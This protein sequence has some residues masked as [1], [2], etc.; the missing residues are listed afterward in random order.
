MGSHRGAEGA[1]R[2]SARAGPW[3]AQCGAE[4]SLRRTTN[5][6]VGVLD[7]KEQCAGAC[8]ATRKAVLRVLVVFPP[9]APSPSVHSPFTRCAPC[10]IQSVHGAPMSQCRVQIPRLAALARDDSRSRTLAPSHPRTLAPSHPRT[11]A[12]AHPRITPARRTTPGTASAA[13]GDIAAAPSPAPLAPPPR[14][15][16]SA[17]RR[18]SPAPAR[19]GPHHRSPRWPPPAPVP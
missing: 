7:G 3:R 2:V 15:R 17:D 13:T 16:A 5:N 6:I 10:E 1:P 9:K 4:R 19:S 12:P 11:R 14:A 18:G 8:S